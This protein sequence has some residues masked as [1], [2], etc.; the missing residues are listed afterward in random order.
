MVKIYNL[1]TIRPVLVENSFQ[2][3][4]DFHNGRGRAALHYH[5]LII[6]DIIVFTL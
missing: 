3:P 6:R 4:E 5:Y 2:L 1:L